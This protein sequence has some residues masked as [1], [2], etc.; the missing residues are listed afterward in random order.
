MTVQTIQSQTISESVNT[1][2]TSSTKFDIRNH[3]D[4]LKPTGRPNRYFCPVCDGND[5]TIGK[6]GAYKCWHDC[7]PRDI[8]EAVA[9]WTDKV[10]G[11]ARFS[12]IPFDR[13]KNKSKKPRQAFV[14]TGLKLA[15]LSESATD[16]PERIQYKKNSYIPSFIK[17]E[18][19]E[20][21]KKYEQ[22]FHS[23]H[24]NTAKP[25]NLIDTLTEISY[26]YSDTQL[27]RRWDWE[28]PHKQ[29]GRNKTCRQ[30]H[31]EEKTDTIK[32]NEGKQPWRA[33]RIEEVIEAA[34]RVTNGI[35]ALL[36]Q[37]G[38]KVVEIGRAEAIASFSFKGSA[39]DK[40]FIIKELTTVKEECGEFA[41]VFL[42]DPDEAGLKKTA[43]LSEV[44]AQLGIPLILVNPQDIIGELA[45]GDVSIDYEKADLEEI[46]QILSFSEF[47]RRLE[48]EIEAAA[49]DFNQ[50]NDEKLEK[51]AVPLYNTF[52]KEAFYKPVCE[53]LNLVYEHCVT[54][55]TFD[56]WILRHLFA[57]DWIVI[58]SAFYKFEPITQ[59]L[60]HVNDQTVQNLIAAAAD[61]AFK[62]KHTDK[63]GWLVDYPYE[64]NSYKE[65]AFKFCRSKLEYAEKL[66]YNV[67]L[68]AFLNCVVDLRTG[69]MLPHDRKYFLKNLIPLNYEPNKECPE[70]FQKFI[71]ES[72]GADMLEIIRTFTAMFLDPTAPYGR[73][74]H[75]IG[76]SGGGKGTLGRFWSS[77][78]G[79]DGSG[80]AANFIDIESP[81]GRHQYLTGK[82][83]F[84]FPDMGGY[85][86]GVR[87][88]YELLDNGEMSGRALFSPT[89][90]TQQWNIRFWLASVDHLQIENAGDGW[91][92]RAY[93]IPVLNRQVNVDPYLRQKLEE[94]K[95]DVIS[96]ALSI[97][98]DERDK[99]L[100]LPPTLERV[101][102]LA[103]DAALY[104]DSTKSFV[105][106]C[107]RPTDDSR[108]GFVESH[109]LHDW[110]TAYCKAH[111][112]SPLGM[113]KF[114]SHLKTILPRNFHD[115][116]WAPM[117]NGKRERIAAHWEGIVPLPS[118][119]FARE[120][121]F[122]DSGENPQ[123]PQN[124]IWDCLKSKCVEGGLSEF[125]DFWNFDLFTLPD[126]PPDTPSNT[127]TNEESAPK[128]PETY[129][130]QG[131][132]TVQAPK[133]QKIDPGQ[134]KTLVQ[135]DCPP[136]PVC[137]P[138][139]FSSEN[140]ETENENPVNPDS[141]NNTDSNLA[142][143]NDG[144]GGHQ[145]CEQVSSED[146]KN[147]QAG[148]FWTLGQNIE[149]MKA[150]IL[151]RSWLHIAELTAKWDKKTKQA[152]WTALSKEEKEI[153][154]S[155][156]PVQFQTQPIIELTLS[157]QITEAWD[158]LTTLGNL[159]LSLKES[160]LVAATVNC[161]SDQIDYIK[162]AANSV[163]KLGVNRDADYNG[164][165]VEI[166]DTGY[167]TNPKV[168][169]KSGSFFKVKRC[170]LTPWLGIE[171]KA[172]SS[173]LPECEVN[174]E[175]EAPEAIQLD[176]VFDWSNPGEP[177]EGF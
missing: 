60:K 71:T 32:W 91:A 62:L 176:W 160:D 29:K 24:L 96:W 163:W 52:D 88:F 112:Y 135:Q 126:T 66:P 56:G 30:C 106:L 139:S 22:Y 119:F 147:G 19:E 59:T 35:P 9:P 103:L 108:L 98:R 77:L 172:Q 175:E 64:A 26:S 99:I 177:I 75:L 8:R 113:S 141:P 45:P 20:E 144:Q 17:Q 125:E 83:I 84:G 171:Y 1:D 154:K 115:R 97:P 134:S 43:L 50:S 16:I 61:K 74:P 54:A 166:F 161:T 142:G 86:E 25:I 152:V 42:H 34:K 2:N 121:G 168:R 12:F 40:K 95:A 13:R 128:S 39:W 57:D 104:G 123:T 155:L 36:L 150:A 100:T 111:G 120:L 149:S 41:I 81:E 73:F 65:S 131:V 136:C 27:V 79:S 117:V 151:L 58:N 44:C 87:T 63:F 10:D 38:E 3:I 145:D 105:D 47:I 127:P 21:Q 174:V 165:R 122:K 46:L 23:E 137:P 78:F 31:I 70:A 140:S 90:Y 15:M 68:L 130:E 94:V 33:Y 89:S 129:T 110:Y 159:V 118:I 49:N 132:Q 133:E 48:L 76:Q 69:E 53:A 51:A 55:Q 164:E 18:I 85:A 7:Q 169:T 102:N 138:Q 67:H 80:S 116:S 156:A 124:K 82:R 5:L 6:D 28:A 146:A 167:G 173:S 148:Q 162:K 14:P 72:F 114:I 109:Q 157:E 170:H 92:R 101:K 4:K 158:D 37:E 143:D 93:P 11:T 107:L 153:V